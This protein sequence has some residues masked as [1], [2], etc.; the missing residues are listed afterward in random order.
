MEDPILGTG[1]AEMKNIRN[2]ISEFGFMDELRVRSMLI[3]TKSGL[4]MSFRFPKG[5]T[6]K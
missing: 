1:V 6:I 5:L 3:F 2:V 4:L